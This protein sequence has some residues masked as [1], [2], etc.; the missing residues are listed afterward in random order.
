MDKITYLAELAEGLARWV[1]E[2]ERRDILRYYA[3]YFE[4]AGP[5]REAEV[6]AELGDPWV[7]SSRLAVE[8]GYVTWEKAASWTPRKRWPKVLLGTAVG[9]FIFV[10]VFNIGMLAVNV[11]HTA[12]SFVMNP[13][14]GQASVVDWG[15]S[16]VWYDEFGIGYVHMDSDPGVYFIASE[17]MTAFS[18]ID[19]DISLGSI[20]VVAG[21]DF[22]VSFQL[23]ESLGGYEPL[24]EVRGGVLRIRDGDLS[25]AT[26]VYVWDDLKKLFSANRLAVDVT[27][28]V[29]ENAA[30]DKISV[31]TGLGD[32]LLYGVNAET[33]TAETGLGNVLLYGLNAETVTAETGLGDVECYEAR[34]ARRLELSTGMGDV[35]L[36]LEMALA[37]LNISLES[38]M[39][40]VEATLCGFETDYSISLESG[41]GSVTVNGVGCGSQVE[42]KHSGASYRLNAESGMGNV[43][44]YFIGSAAATMESYTGYFFSQTN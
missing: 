22:T 16:P 40:N 10:M 13:V 19:A 21:N 29:P 17:S 23:S 41:M 20:H 3:E 35:N 44:V 33:V 15:M 43:N 24:C 7:L 28:T 32:V 37:G 25:R 27:V 4:E 8:G 1:P 26:Q 34:S 18:S 42:R 31:K 2:R 36:E 38:G 12:G 39:G 9:L 11:T 5:G 30:L 14:I 6:V